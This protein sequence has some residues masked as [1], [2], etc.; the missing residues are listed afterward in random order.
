MS[1][2]K[3]A[4]LQDQVTLMSLN[5]FGRTL[6]ASNADGRSHNPNHQVSF[7]IGKPFRPGVIGGV[8]PVEK[9]Y[10]AVAIDSKTGKGAPGA[11]IAAADTLA[12]FGQTM[13]A[14]VGVAQDVITRQIT[15]GK[16]IAGALAQG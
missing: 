4:G 7:T 13:L 3:A 2:L 6:N 15:K 16:V 11:D 14:G 12:S 9:D 8:A 10:G 5:V 1:Q